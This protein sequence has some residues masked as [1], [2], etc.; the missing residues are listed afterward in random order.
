MELM[1]MK[2]VNLKRVIP[3]FGLALFILAVGVLYR[4]LHTYRLNDIISGDHQG[5]TV[6][7]GQPLVGVLFLER[8]GVYL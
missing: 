1:P 7:L 6:L 2:A 5:C 4:E 3:F 8:F